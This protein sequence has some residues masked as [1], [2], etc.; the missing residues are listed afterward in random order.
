MI[1]VPGTYTEERRVYTE[2]AAVRS[3]EPNRG[4]HWIL[5]GGGN[6]DPGLICRTMEEESDSGVPCRIL[7][8]DAGVP[9]TEAAGYKPDMVLGD[10]DSVTDED[11][12]RIIDQYPERV[13]LDPVKDDTDMEAAIRFILRKNPSKI[14]ILGGTGS[15]M[16]HTMTNLRLLVIAAGAGVPAVLLDTTNR[17]RVLTGSVTLKRE[18]LFGTYVSLLPV[19]GEVRGITL[20]GFRYGLSDAALYPF[21]SLGISNELTGEEGEILFSGGMLYMMETKDE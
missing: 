17:I 9:A 13:L 19:E 16:D 10:F 2:S 6:A 7:G 18:D 21:S 14:T 11:R 4:E 15:R 1:P 5:V 12:K 8:I 20:R 3:S